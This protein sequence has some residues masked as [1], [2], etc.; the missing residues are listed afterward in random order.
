M[1]HAILLVHV[2][3]HALKR[4]GCYRGASSCQQPARFIS[5]RTFLY[6]GKD[7]KLRKRYIG[8]ERP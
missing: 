4:R 6:Y 2:D 1:R 5:R 8:K 3:S 7:D